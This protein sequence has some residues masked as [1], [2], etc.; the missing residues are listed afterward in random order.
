M[1]T[2]HFVAKEFHIQ[3]SFAFS[4]KSDNLIKVGGLPNNFLS[5]SRKNNVKYEVIKLEAPH[6]EVESYIQEVL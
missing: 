3:L 5:Y 4:L 1:H 2:G 6:N